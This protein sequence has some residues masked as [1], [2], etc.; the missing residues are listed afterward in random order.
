MLDGTEVN[1]LTL[2]RNKNS[3][4]P[5][6]FRLF[7]ENELT[8]AAA[9]MAYYLVFA[10]FPLLMVIHASL[11]MVLLDY[12]IQTSFFYSLLPNMLEDLVETY[13]QH[14]GENSNL[15]FMFLGIFLTVYTLSKFMKSAKRTIR[16]IYGSGRSKYVITEWS[17]SVI[18]SLLIIAAF[19]VSLF[20]L[21]LGGQ[22]VGFLESTFPM[23]RM[24]HLEAV[25]RFLFTA[26]TIYAVVTLFYLWIPHVRQGFWNVLP[27]TVFT[28]V[29]WVLVSTL[30][31]FY[32]NHFSKYSLI[33]GSIGAFIML[34]LWIYMSSLILLLGA[35]INAA[36]YKPR[37]QTATKP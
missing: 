22:I 36:L 3:F 29:C 6:A 26:A 28:S 27:G 24:L 4:L 31:S 32:M 2:F 19:Y 10:F 12:D 5:R 1:E 37:R 8:A 25:T 16:R 9:E 17:I 18:L 14:V 34:M 21:I 35:V 11:S 20:L 33:Y 13:L 30:F 15:S 23:F 7:I